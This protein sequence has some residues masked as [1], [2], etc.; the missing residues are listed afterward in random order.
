MS[1][2]LDSETRLSLERALDR[3]GAGKR[4]LP[5]PMLAPWQEFHDMKKT[6]MVWRMGSGEIYLQ[7]FFE[8]Y[9]GQDDQKRQAYKAGNPPPEEWSG[10]FDTLDLRIL[11][12][13]E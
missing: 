13:T 11:R 4:R 8:W 3:L 7:W 10:F 1:T 6:S 12:K 5:D 2:Q 9:A